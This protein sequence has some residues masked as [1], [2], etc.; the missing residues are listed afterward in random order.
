MKRY[1]LWIV[2]TH[3]TIVLS[4]VFFV[5]FCIDRVNP[6]MEFIGSD[7]SDWLLGAFCLIALASS[8]FAA[9]HLYKHYDK[10]K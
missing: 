2:L 5:F 4:I 9:V 8:I 10:K 7:I 6:A 1:G 3:A